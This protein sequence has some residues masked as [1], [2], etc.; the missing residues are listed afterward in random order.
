MDTLLL[1]S[2]LCPH[3]LQGAVCWLPLDR[4]KSMTM[5]AWLYLQ[6]MAHVGLEAST[7]PTGQRT[8]RGILKERI[9]ILTVRW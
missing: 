1:M 2:K 8:V 7:E 4:A 3:P 6:R 9:S 5:A